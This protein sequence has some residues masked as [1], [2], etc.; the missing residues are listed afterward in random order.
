MSR[1]AAAS[2]A[3]CLLLLGIASI[4][5][6][7][8]SARARQAPANPNQLAAKVERAPLNLVPAERYLLPG[9]LQPLREVRILTPHDGIVRS[10]PLA[11]GSAVREGQEVGRMDETDARIRSKIAEARIRLETSD[12]ERIRDGLARGDRSKSDAQAAEA[13]VEIAKLEHELLQNE[14]FRCILHAPFAGRISAIPVSAGQFLMKGSTVLEIADLAT[15]RA[16]V[17]VDRT[18]VQVGGKLN[19]LVEGR[20]VAADV[21]ALLPLPE[22]HAVLRE[23]AAPMALAVV[24]IA[25]ADNSLEPGRRVVGP[26]LPTTPIASVASYAIKQDDQGEPLVQV[27]RAERVVNVPIRVV[28]ALGPDRSQV[29]GLFR[30]SDALI[31]SSSVPLV[32]GT[33]I[34][35]EDAPAAAGVEAVAPPSNLYGESAVVGGRAPGRPGSVPAVPTV[36]TYTPPPTKPATKPATKGFVPF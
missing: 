32:P 36:P 10:L 21:R 34:R 3:T 5:F 31:Q 15:L 14:L 6:P 24:E 2:V 19:V 33:F 12:V 35:F 18:A 25:N 4:A 8:R 11:L 27:I 28:G 7:D 16:F 22:T 1:R 30:P 20:G 23:L 26:H 9:L 29:T 13:R 17:P